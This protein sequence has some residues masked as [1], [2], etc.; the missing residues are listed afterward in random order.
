MEQS[1]Q[2]W[3]PTSSGRRR[4]DDKVNAAGYSYK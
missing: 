2:A 3:D 1:L 4:Y